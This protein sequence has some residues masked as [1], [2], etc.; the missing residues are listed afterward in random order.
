[1]AGRRK[2]KI[3]DDTDIDAETMKSMEYTAELLAT[4]FWSA[5]KKAYS[6]T[7]DEN[8]ALSAGMSCENVFL[9]VTSERS[10]ESKKQMNPVDAIIAAALAQQQNGD[11]DN[12]N[13]RS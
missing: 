2:K 11:D 5:Y 7:G 8:L 13:D 9:E 12:D 3:T 1:M 4:V 6:E 10:L